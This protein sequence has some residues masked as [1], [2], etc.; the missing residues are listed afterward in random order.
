MATGDVMGGSTAGSAE[1][2]AIVALGETRLTEGVLTGVTFR[3]RGRD[4]AAQLDRP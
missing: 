3:D 4:I 1:R 2:C